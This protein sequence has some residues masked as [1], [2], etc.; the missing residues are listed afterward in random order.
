MRRDM[1]SSGLRRTLSLAVMSASLT[2]L[3][4]VINLSA[5]RSQRAYDQVTRLENF[6][7]QLDSS[8]NI[9]AGNQWGRNLS[10]YPNLVGIY[11]I[12]DRLLLL[13]A[14][15]TQ[16]Q[17]IVDPYSGKSLPLDQSHSDE[18]V[19]LIQSGRQE[20]E[21]SSLQ[22]KEG[23]LVRM[24]GSSWQTWSCQSNFPSYM[25]A[26]NTQSGLIRSFF[27]VV[28]FPLRRERVGRCTGVLPPHQKI[29]TTLD[30]AAIA[31]LG[32]SD[33]TLLLF[34]RS[35]GYLLRLDA[36]FR[37]HTTLNN[38]VFTVD[39]ALIIDKFS[40]EPAERYRV[41]KEAVDD[42]DSETSR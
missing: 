39:A 4:E 9:V 17:L 13:V 34:D 42:V 20:M 18:L 8:Q 36:K 40:G 32:L 21:V 16:K 23:I 35:H 2:V 22:T 12:R 11:R 26:S 24:E 28:R 7:E 15:N 3:S 29:D 6:L 31:M 33:R 1:I 14:Q 27:V 37:Q 5:A 10:S 25:I 19:S 38:K 41:V 30:E